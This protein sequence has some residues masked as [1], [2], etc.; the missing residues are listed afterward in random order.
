MIYCNEEEFL[1]AQWDA[2]H[3]GG[4]LADVVLPTYCGCNEL[5]RNS[6]QLETHVERGCW[7]SNGA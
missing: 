5:L 6:Q 7:R 1:I 2:Q 4:T 3:E